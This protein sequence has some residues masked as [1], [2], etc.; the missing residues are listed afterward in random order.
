[1]HILQDVH[2]MLPCR[3]LLFEY[4]PDWKVQYR[5][6]PPFVIDNH[7]AKGERVY[8]KINYGSGSVTW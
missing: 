4:L 2:S 6:F 3:R 5:G 8:V 7:W 1:M